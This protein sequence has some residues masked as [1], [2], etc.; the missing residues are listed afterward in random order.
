LYFRIFSEC[1]LI[2]F[3]SPEIAVSVDRHVRF[4]YRGL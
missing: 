4:Y 3:L 2:T 1:F